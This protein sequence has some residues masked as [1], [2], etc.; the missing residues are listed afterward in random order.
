MSNMYPIKMNKSQYKLVEEQA[1]CYLHGLNHDMDLQ[2]MLAKMYASAFDDADDAAA[3]AAASEVLTAV[4]G[5]AN[6]YNEAAYGVEHAAYSDVKPYIETHLMRFIKA[7]EKGM[8]CKEACTYWTRFLAALTVAGV[9][10]KDEKSRKAMMAFVSGLET[11]EEEATPEQLQSL[12]ERVLGRLA[13]SS[14]MLVGLGGHEKMLRAMADG[15]QAGRLLLSVNGDERAFRA[16]MAMMT[17][18]LVKKGEMPGVPAGMPLTTSAVLFCTLHERIKIEERYGFDSL[19]ERIVYA[20]LMLLGGVASLMLAGFALVLGL[21]LIF[22]FIPLLL[23]LPAVLALYLGVWY[24]V[25]CA[26]VKNGA[27]IDKLDKPVHYAFIALRAAARGV[28]KLA[29]RV[30][31]AVAPVAVKAGAYMLDKTWEKKNS[32][33]DAA[34]H[35]ARP[36][37][38]A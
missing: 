28:G 12:H 31:K 35:R 20:L 7:S 4:D 13:H 21:E 19:P 5:F 29:A 18:I 17:G 16:A 8:S 32:V 37:A 34:R 1:A 9:Q 23:C 25:D 3:Q 11:S 10:R 26:V 27:L 38:Y 6:L 15:D 24:L 33:K 14:T 30:A 36:H 22:D 2:A